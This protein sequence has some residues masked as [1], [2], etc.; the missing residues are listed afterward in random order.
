VSRAVLRRADRVV[1]LGESMRERCLAGGAAPDRTVVIPNWADPA[2]VR[3]IPHPENPL[4]AKLAAGAATLVMYS[5][6]MGRG[7]DLATLLEAARLL[8]DRKDVAF[9]FVGDGAKRAQVE[10]AARALPNLR[11]APYQPRERLAESLSAG[12]VHLVALDRELEGLVEP[13]KLYGIMAAGR[14]ALFVGPPGSEVARTI[15]REGCG[16]VVPNGDAAG[17]AAAI[18]EMAADEGMRAAVGRRARQA[19]AERYSRRAA[20]AAFLR[21][22]EG[23]AGPAGRPR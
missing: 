1:A 18:R 2:A 4:R 12:D 8:R 11:L 14:P 22:L 20:T 15:A 6:N 23:L 17:L 19:L 5:G 16:R 9:L 3:P 13:S 10:A 7:H 21:L